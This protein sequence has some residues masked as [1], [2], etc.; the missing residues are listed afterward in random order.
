[1]RSDGLPRDDDAQ[2]FH[3]EFDV[4][5]RAKRRSASR[6]RTPFHSDDFIWFQSARS[7]GAPRDGAAGDTSGAPHEFQSARSDGSPRDAASTSRCHPRSRFNPRAATDRRATTIHGKVSSSTIVSI[8][9]QRRIAARPRR[10]RIAIPAR[11]VSIRAQ[12]RIAARLPPKYEGR[13]VMLFQSARSDGSPRD[14]L[15]TNAPD[16]FRWFQSARSDGS[17]RDSR[18][19]PN[20]QPRRCFNPRAATDRRATPPPPYCDTRPTCFNPRAA[21]DRRATPDS[22]YIGYAGGVSIRAQRRIAARRNPTGIAKGDRSFQSA[23]SDGSPRDQR[24][25]ASTVKRSKFQSARSDGSPR[26]F[27]AATS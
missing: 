4:S 15:M 22:L 21:T 9:A 23:R 25:T 11:L 14:W 27:S 26:D 13:P 16:A 6:R 17:P 5:I 1:M 7:A 8:R 12:R 24:G 19:S 3:G 20:P 2:C 10:P 18:P